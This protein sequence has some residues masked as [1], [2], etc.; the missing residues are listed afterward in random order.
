MACFSSSTT[1]VSLKFGA[2]AFARNC[3]PGYLH[4][5][6]SFPVSRTLDGGLCSPIRVEN[7]NRA[8][9]SNLTFGALKGR[10]L[11]TTLSSTNGHVKVPGKIRFGAVLGYTEFYLLSLI[12]QRG[13]FIKLFT[14]DASQ[15]KNSW[16]LNTGH[17]CFF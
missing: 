3:L 2:K 16:I 4:S 13:N 7:E 10:H 17:I 1:K 14:H 9:G 15:K 6:V 11:N 12:K 8:Y 5:V